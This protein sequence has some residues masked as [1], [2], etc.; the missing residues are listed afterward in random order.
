MQEW[1][2]TTDENLKMKDTKINELSKKCEDFHKL[3]AENQ[4]LRR[5]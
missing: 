2:K 1:R 3:K 4:M 5:N